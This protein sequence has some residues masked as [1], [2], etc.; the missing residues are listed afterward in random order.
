[1]DMKN[2]NWSSEFP[3]VPEFVHQTVLST[4]E[5]LNCGKVKRVKHMKKRTIVILAAA[6]VAI[7]GTTVSA[8]EI[9]NWNER[10]TEVFEAEEEQQKELV[11]DQIAQEEYQTVSD[12][13]LT[14][15][16]VQTIQDINCF[17]ALFEITA[18]NKE[19]QIV[20][21]SNMSFSIDY[22]GKE[23]P[24]SMLGCGF[25]DEN[26]QK[27]SN[28]RYY[29]IFGTKTDTNKEDLN[30]TIQFTSLDAPEEKALEG[31]KVLEGSWEFSLN[32]HTVDAVCFEVNKEYQ[33]AGCNVMVKAVE[34]T[35][36]SVKLICDESSA[37]ELE[38]LEGINIDQADSLR[39]L[40][41]NGVK[42]NDG[43][44]IEEDGFQEL[45]VGFENGN[46][47]KTAR[48]SRVI[49]VEKVSALLV[50]ENKEEIELP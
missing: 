28:S 16:A 43:S 26:R 29:E 46:Y 37:R 21:G 49:D 50:G 32:V 19:M 48:F 42:Y 38:K 41:I 22:Q 1:M 10:A 8:T 31:T 11:M 33:V 24:I 45:S 23:N 34:L 20:P 7:L 44:I 13:G 2:R 15:R 9:F 25:V 18:E 36:I 30:M 4:L 3:E 47:E 12:S 40:F 14:I 17:Y 35:P 6:L 27:V 39:S 5:E